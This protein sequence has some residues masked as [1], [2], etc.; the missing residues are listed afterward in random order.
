[1]LIDWIASRMPSLAEGRVPFPVLGDLVILSDG[2]FNRDLREILKRGEYA[3][4]VIRA[5]WVVPVSDGVEDVARGL[6]GVRLN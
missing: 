5:G 6:S 2:F 1:M 4:R 3:H